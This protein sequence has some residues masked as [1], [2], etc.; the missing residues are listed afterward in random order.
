[1]RQWLKVYGIPQDIQYKMFCDLAF[2]KIKRLK[3]AENK[4]FTSFGGDTKL[5]NGRSLFEVWR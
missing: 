2:M 3:T 4:I 5:S 1:M